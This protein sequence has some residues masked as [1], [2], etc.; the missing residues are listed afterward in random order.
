MKHPAIAVVLVLV[1]ALAPSATAAKGP[2]PSS[3]ASSIDQY[4]EQVPTASGSVPVGKGSGHAARLSP[5]AQ[6]A[7]AKSGGSDASTL[8]KVAESSQYGAPAQ[9][10]ARRQPATTPATPARVARG[11][12]K[13]AASRAHATGTTPSPAASSATLGAAPPTHAPSAVAAAGSTFR[14]GRLWILVVALVAVT[15]AGALLARR[16]RGHS[17]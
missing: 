11:T 15:A 6:K 10:P 4:V 14:F 1:A 8:Q 3:S 16:Q 2:G 17:S 13:G 12:A 7:L 5:A 9:T